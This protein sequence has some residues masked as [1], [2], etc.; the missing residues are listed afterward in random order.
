MKRQPRGFTLVELMVVC[1]MAG[2]LVTL[3]LPAWN[4]QQLRAARIDAVDALTRLQA[5]HE[6]YRGLHGLYSSELPALRGA[7]RS[8]P[9]AATRSSWH[10]PEPTATARW[11]ERAARKPPIVTAWSCRCR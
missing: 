6:S 8:A 4:Q 11:R 9:R 7:A 1:A 5:A 3:A 2:V 10:P